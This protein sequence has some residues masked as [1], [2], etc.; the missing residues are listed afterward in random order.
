MIEILLCVKALNSLVLKTWIA[1]PNLVS[2]QLRDSYIVLLNAITE[3]LDL[4]QDD[5]LRTKYPEPFQEARGLHQ[6]CC[7]LD[8]KYQ[9]A[10][11]KTPVDW[12][13]VWKVLNDKVPNTLASL[14][15]RAVAEE[16]K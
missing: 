12:P 14:L 1:P 10:G 13:M 4:K 15:E 2:L 6:M 5:P 8:H 16:S 3:N 9:V 11:V 7:I